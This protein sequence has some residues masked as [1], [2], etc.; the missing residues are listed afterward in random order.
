VLRVVLNKAYEIPAFWSSNEQEHWV[1]MKI[2]EG[3][4]RE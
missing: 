4:V 1:M 3:G 2:K